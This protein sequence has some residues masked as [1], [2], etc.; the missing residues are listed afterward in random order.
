LTVGELRKQLEGLPD[1]APVFY[2]RIEDAYFD[3]HGWTA[4]R[5]MPSP[6]FPG[7]VDDYIRAFGVVRYHNERALFLTAH[8]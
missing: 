8:Y 7:S 3:R 2:Q 5:I 6:D 4:D 1:D